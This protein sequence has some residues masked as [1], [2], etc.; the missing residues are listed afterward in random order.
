MISH[1]DLLEIKKTGSRMAHSPPAP[2]G[3]IVC[4]SVLAAP[5]RRVDASTLRSNTTLTDT[6]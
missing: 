1:F 6:R 2:V 4:N 3:V 5:S